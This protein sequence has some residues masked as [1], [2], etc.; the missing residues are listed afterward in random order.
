MEPPLIIAS[1]ACA[2]CGSDVDHGSE[3]CV[4]CDAPLAPAKISN[5]NTRPGHR[6]V[7]DDRWQLMLLLFGAMGV[8]G[9]PLLW[10]SRAFGVLSKLLLSLAVTA[11]TAALVAFC[12]WSWSWSMGRLGEIA[13]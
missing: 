13:W 5:G 3:R 2:H 11:W 9:I 6:P 8:L 4:H 7:I 1:V 10:Y 12:W